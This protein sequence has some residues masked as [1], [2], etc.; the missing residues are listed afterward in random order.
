MR[1]LPDVSL[2]HQSKSPAQLRAGGGGVNKAFRAM[3]VHLPS[4]HRR[5]IEMVVLNRRS[6]RAAAA[7][8][9]MVPGVVTRTVRRLRNR[10]ACPVR[11]ALALHLDTLPEPTRSLAV[12]HFFAGLSYKQLVSNHRLTER[13]V[14]DQLSYVRGW[15]R[16]LNRRRAEQQRALRARLATRAAEHEHDGIEAA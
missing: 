3:L 7:E 16:A 15:L 10:L 2:I 8:L 5:L 11:R 1:T 14:R 6:H 4:D 9:R 13:E 12:D